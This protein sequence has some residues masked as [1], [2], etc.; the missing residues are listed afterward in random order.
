MEGHTCI[1]HF[2]PF[3]KQAQKSP[4][5]RPPPPPSDPPPPATLCSHPPPRAAACTS[6][7]TA[8]SH[9]DTRPPPPSPGSTRQACCAAGRL[10]HEGARRLDQL[11]HVL[12]V[13][14]KLHLGQKSGRRRGPGQPPSGVAPRGQESRPNGPILPRAPLPDRVPGEKFGARY[15]QPRPARTGCSTRRRLPHTMMVVVGGWRLVVGGGWWW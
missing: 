8:R 4:L 9:T 13:A 7:G 15:L 2:G 14:S 3:E 1:I 5:Y 10:G 6:P 12:R 11:R